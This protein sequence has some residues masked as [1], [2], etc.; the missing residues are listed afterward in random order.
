MMDDDENEGKEDIEDREPQV[1]SSD[2]KERK[3]ARQLRIERRLEAI[4]RQNL[5]EGEEIEETVKPTLLQEQLQKSYKLLEN[6]TVEGNEYITNVRIANDSREANRREEEDLIRVNILEQLEKEAASAETQFNEINE[7]WA[8]ILNYNDPLQINEEIISQKEKCDVL[9][10]QKDEM[11]A[12]LKNEV[13]KCELKFEADQRKQVEDIQTLSNRIETQISLMRRAYRCELELIEGVILVERKILI[14]T[15][16][17]RWEELHKKRD[18]EENLNC[19]TKFEQLEDFEEICTAL[20]VNHQEKYRN[21]RIKLGND[22]EN[23]E[24]ELEKI[25]SLALINSEKLDYNYQVL[26]KREN[27]NVTIKSQQ[28]RRIN[29]LQDNI[30]TLR[31][32]TREYL[33]Q[34]NNEIGKLTENIRK[35]Q[36]SVLDVEAKADSFSHINDLKYKQVWDFNKERIDA[37]LK[38]ILDTDRVLHEQQLGLEWVNPQSE[39]LDKTDLPSYVSAMEMLNNICLKKESNVESELGVESS[40][41]I[42]CDVEDTVAH[43]RILRIVLKLIADKSGFLIEEKLKQ[44][45]EPY[46]EQEI[47]LVKI[48][49]V[50]S[51]LEIKHKDEIEVLLEYFLPYTHCAICSEQLSTTSENVEK[52]LKTCDLSSG[53][54]NSVD[55]PFVLTNAEEVK[56]EEDSNILSAVYQPSEVIA[57]IIS[58]ITNTQNSIEAIP[59]NE[60]DETTKKSV[61]IAEEAMTV[62]PR[63]H[64]PKT[65][66]HKKH[67]LVISSVYILRALREFLSKFYLEKESV[68]TMTSRLSRK[69]STISRLMAEN[70]VKTYWERYRTEFSSEREDIWDALLI[71][72][73]KYHEI[74]KDRRKLNS[75]VIELRQQNLQLQNLLDSYQ[76]AEGSKIKPP[77]AL[78]REV[79][80]KHV[81]FHS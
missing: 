56:F 37:L 52:E 66:C 15:N 38:Q 33:E 41:E 49:A 47:S 45:L 80:I 32:K 70:D 11:I 20:R 76:R 67:A 78:Q 10:K 34:T 42:S 26:K 51:A 3:L 35:L 63:G 17:K 46:T 21:I 36:L 71:G 29:K 7:K 81:S 62:K 53:S 74:L 19:V 43:R 28:K 58:T 72:L 4:R 22:I 79:Q 60:P 69:R 31:T 14:D 16:D 64:I 68:L 40:D 54:S 25:K 48:D 73:Q 12:N 55:R 27:E 65:L 18:L 5:P 59:L 6:L 23:L 24:R 13:K 8:S 57:S 75:E 9:I 50:F 30:N 77:C 2:P 61:V 1:T 39:L 44:V